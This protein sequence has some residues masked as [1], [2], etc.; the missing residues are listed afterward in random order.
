MTIY[1]KSF[2]IAVLLFMTIP[3]FA[4]R[5]LATD[6]CFTVS[7]GSMLLESGVAGA[8]VTGFD[9]TMN[10]VTSF[11]YGLFDNMDV[12]IDIPI[13]SIIPKNGDNSVGFSDLVLK[14]KI[15]IIPLENHF[16]SVAMVFGSK[17]ANGNANSGLGSGATD[18]FVSSI[19]TKDLK[20]SK[21]HVNLGYSL[22]G[23]PAG[24]TLKDIIG[25]GISYEYLGIENVGILGEIY[26]N[27]NSDPTVSINPLEL[28]IGGNMKIQPGII[29]DV[30][31]AFGLSDV[32]PKNRYTIG[33]T[34]EF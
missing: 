2:F 24:S 8:T 4:C 32:S 34:V 14:T 26:G 17:L 9:Q 10:W 19:F 12:G 29:A 1:V 5:P 21:I 6:D 13:V 25:Y 28:L 18:F 20:N 31:V 16:A 15:N 23:K 33:L 3:V 22:I 7:K 30:G 11:K 27:T